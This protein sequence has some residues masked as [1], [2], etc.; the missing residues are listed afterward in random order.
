MVGLILEGLFALME[1]QVSVRVRK[2]DVDIAKNATSEASSEFEKSSN[3][4][5]SIS[6]DE[7]EFL[8]DSC[9][10]GV[11]IIN[12]TGKIDVNNTLEE[13][14][15]LLSETALPDIRLALFGSTASRKFFD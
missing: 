3:K 2:Q 5:V 11:V 1:E 15:K 7:S 13:R 8:P 12:S 10:G 14:L 6:V 9:S 4:P